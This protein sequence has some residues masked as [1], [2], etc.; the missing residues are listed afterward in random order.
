MFP[1]ALLCLLAWMSDAG[2]SQN[3]P[4]RAY[5]PEHGIPTAAELYEA[6]PE[7]YKACL[8]HEPCAQ[9]LDKADSHIPAVPPQ[10]FKE[11]SINC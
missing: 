3:P 2:E 6:C 1:A 11:L 5:M 8:D 10:F 7:Q 9:T 4:S